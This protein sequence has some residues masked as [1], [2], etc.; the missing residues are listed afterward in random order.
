MLS[1]IPP[2]PWPPCPPDTTERTG[3]PLVDNQK[4]PRDPAS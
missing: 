1:N 2:E 4:D 3:A